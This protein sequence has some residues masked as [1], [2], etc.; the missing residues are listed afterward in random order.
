MNT[1]QVANRLVELCRIGENMQ[2]LNELYD[3]NVISKEMP[4]SPNPITNGKEAVIKKSEDWYA[5]VEEFHGGEIS[6]P[7]IAEN[8]F[9]C[10]MK[11]DCTFKGQGRMQIEEVAV[12]QVNN[13][14][15]TEEQFFYNMPS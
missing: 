11:M 14:K 7:L 4:G 8:H 15:I 3:Q 12:Y 1:Q 13:G 2:A 6:D 10:T 5:S 9:S